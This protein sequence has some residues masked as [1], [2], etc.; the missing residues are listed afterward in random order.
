MR[1]VHPSATLLAAS[2]DFGEIP[3]TFES[4]D[5][6]WLAL[7]ERRYRAF[8]ATRTHTGPSVFTVRFEPTRVPAPAELVTPLAAHLEAIEMRKTPEGFRVSS[9]TTSCN[10]DLP[11]RKAHL[12]G[13]SA[14][15]PLDNLLR[16]LLPLLWNEGVLVHG[17]FLVRR[18]GGGL[19][20]GGPSGAGKSTLS[21]LASTHALCDELTAVRVEKADARLVS[22][23]FWE[24]RPGRAP[25]DALLFLSH[26]A[27]HRLIP[28]SPGRALRRLVPLVLWPVW[29][30]GAMASAFAHVTRLLESRPAFELAFAPRPDVWEFIE[31]EVPRP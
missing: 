7:L 29:D 6:A 5:E 17:A 21:R 2:Y 1:D 18:S 20:A 3:F 14:M 25:L 22:L 23:P 13:P 11:S 30:D 10:I 16:H 9:A 8:R 31:K 28:L 24:S 19:L 15:Y 27:S 12:R 26:G 4:D